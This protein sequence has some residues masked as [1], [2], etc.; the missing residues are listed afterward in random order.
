MSEQQVDE[1]D[2]QRAEQP[3][4]DTGEQVE[5]LPWWHSK[6]NLTAIAV[7]IALVFGAL[8]WV[9]GNNRAT[10]DPSAKDVGFLQD[11]RW[12][13]DQAID[14]AIIFLDLPGTDLQLRRDAQ[15]ILVGQSQG[16]GLM[17]QLLRSFGKPEDPPTDIGMAWMGEPTLLDRMP[18][19]ASAEQL[20]ALRLSSGA[21][22]DETFVTLMVAHHQGGLHMAQYIVDYGTDSSVKELAQTIVTAQTDEISILRTD[23]AASK[24]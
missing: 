17:V 8:G 6:V 12:H 13:H 5:V 2:G 19:M 16:T 18:G 10:A 9:I 7:G 1:R 20:D 14:M 24:A 4:P 21:V 3:E 15:D 11:M 22:A 23:L